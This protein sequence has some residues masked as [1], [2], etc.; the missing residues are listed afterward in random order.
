[1]H[2]QHRHF[3]RGLQAP[4]RRGSGHEVGEFV[5]AATQ[6]SSQEQ[7]RPSCLSLVVQHFPATI[8]IHPV[9]FRHTA[10][11]CPETA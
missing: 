4:V 1:V 8:R 3:I 10:P 6:R 5:P 9:I 7:R 11:S 2:E